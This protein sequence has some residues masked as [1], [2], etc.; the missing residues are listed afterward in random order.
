MG[1]LS[2]TELRLRSAADPTS[3]E[4]AKRRLWQTTYQ[5]AFCSEF[6]ST[7]SKTITQRGPPTEPWAI[8]GTMTHTAP[9]L[10]ALRRK[11]EKEDAAQTPIVR[12]LAAAKLK[13]PP[14]DPRRG[15]IDDLDLDIL[16]L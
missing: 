5:E 7:I 8:V 13:G 2:P 14:R 11:A 1:S 16:D 6:P 9:K 10:R 12:S 3:I 4:L 15:P